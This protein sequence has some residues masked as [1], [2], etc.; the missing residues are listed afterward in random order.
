MSP[1][2]ALLFLT[3]PFIFWFVKLRPWNEV[4]PLF[5]FVFYSGLTEFMFLLIYS[6]AQSNC[7][8]LLLCSLVFFVCFSFWFFSLQSP[9]VL[10]WLCSF[11]SSL[12]F[13]HLRNVHFV[14]MLLLS[15]LLRLQI[16]SSPPVLPFALIDGFSWTTS[17]PYLGPSSLPATFPRLG[18]A[19]HPPSYS[20]GA[21]TWK[22]FG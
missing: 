5:C 11:N 9:S 6:V 2:F 19:F 22:K 14:A 18:I 7:G 20:L 15:I 13:I 16:D 3:N 21:G 8:G 1:A 10:C 4:F 12:H 17:E